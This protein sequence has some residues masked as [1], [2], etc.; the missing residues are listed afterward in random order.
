METFLS[1]CIGVGLS[2][3]CGFRVFIPMLILSGASLFGNFELFESVAWLGS[4][5]VFICLVI[6]TVCEVLAY[7]IPWLDNL[8]DSIASPM[9]VIA[10]AL[11]SYSVFTDMPPWAHWGLAIIAGGGAAGLVQ[12]GS[13]QTRLVS[14]ATTGGF[15]NPIVSTIESIGAV[16]L[17]IFSI[18]LPVI[19]LVLFSDFIGW[20][21]LF[22]QIGQ[23]SH[24]SHDL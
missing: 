2:A 19:A 16:L 24:S 10:G 3:A 6:A 8:L 4:W 15:G 14:T 23:E 1:I 13:V 21:L 22:L 12:L 9:A 11:V 17:S 5:P 18:F 20:C 7:Y